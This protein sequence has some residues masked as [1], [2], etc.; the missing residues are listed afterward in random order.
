[1]LLGASL[2][3]VP[4]IVTWS[5]VQWSSVWTDQLTRGAM[6]EAKAYTQFFSA[7]GAILGCIGGALLGGWLGRRI[8]YFLLCLCS[9]AAALFFFL[10]NDRFGVQFLFST[11]VLGFFSASFY[12]WLPLYLPELFA[13]RIRATGQGFS[14]NFGRNLAVVGALATGQLTGALQGHY[15][16]A[17][18][19]MS[20]MYVV[21]M[22]IIWLAPETRGKPLP[23]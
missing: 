22:A 15:N 10:G 21:G 16:R 3:G 17:C 12:G 5:S 7:L 14:Y 4:L 23:E 9:L 13:T 8:T 11:F 20:L 19:I 2:G 18:A 6:Q 1:M